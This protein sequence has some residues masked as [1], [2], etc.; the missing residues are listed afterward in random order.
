MLLLTFTNSN[1]CLLIKLP[2]GSQKVVVGFYAD[3]RSL[4]FRLT[5]QSRF[6]RGAYRSGQQKNWQTWRTNQSDATLPPRP[7]KQA[8]HSYKYAKWCRASGPLMRNRTW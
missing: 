6:S 5:S 3:W 4:N 1:R 8:S 7:Y 2:S